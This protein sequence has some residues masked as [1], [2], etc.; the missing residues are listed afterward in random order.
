MGRNN[1]RPRWQPRLPHVGAAAAC[2]A[3]AN[4]KPLDRV[5]PALQLHLAPVFASSFARGASVKSMAAFGKRGRGPLSFSVFRD[6]DDER[7]DGRE[8]PQSRPRQHLTTYFG[9]TDRLALT[10][11][12][13]PCSASRH[14]RC[15]SLNTDDLV[16]RRLSQ[17]LEPVDAPLSQRASATL[18][19]LLSAPASP[20]LSQVTCDSAH[21]NSSGFAQLSPGHQ[22]GS[23][24]LASNSSSNPFTEQ[25]SLSD[26]S[27][28][29]TTSNS[30]LQH[31]SSDLTDTTVTDAPSITPDYTFN[32]RKRKTLRD[33]AKMS[34]ERKPKEQ[35]TPESGTPTQMTSR[36]ASSASLL[37][38]VSGVLAEKSANLKRSL[39]FLPTAAEPPKP[40]STLSIG[41][42]YDVRQGAGAMSNPPRPPKPGEDHRE[43]GAPD[44]VER[45]PII[46]EVGKIAEDQM[47]DKRQASNANGSEP[48]SRTQQRGS[49]DITVA[50]REESQPSSH[51]GVSMGS[52]SMECSAGGAQKG[53]IYSEESPSM[54]AL[55]T[56]PPT[57]MGLRQLVSSANRMSRLG[58]NEQ[59]SAQSIDKDDGVSIS[60]TAA[61]LSA[62]KQPVK[63]S[64]FQKMK[65]TF[66]LSRRHKRRNTTFH[67]A[68]E[69]STPI[70]DNDHQPAALQGNLRASQSAAMLTS[71]S[72]VHIGRQKSPS[73]IEDVDLVKDTPPMRRHH[74]AE[75]PPIKSG[76]EFTFSH[77]SLLGNAGKAP[78][79]RDESRPSSESQ[80]NIPSAATP[81]EITSRA[82]SANSA[83]SHG[84]GS[85]DGRPPFTK[86]QHIP[87][88]LSIAGH[89]G[90]HCMD[91]LRSHGNILEFAEYPTVADITRPSATAQPVPAQVLPAQAAPGQTANAQIAAA[92]APTHDTGSPAGSLHQNATLEDVAN[93]SEFTTIVS[94]NLA[95]T[96]LTS[97]SDRAS[98]MSI[99]GVSPRRARAGTADSILAGRR[100]RNRRSKCWNNQ[101]LSP[102]EMMILRPSYDF[103]WPMGESNNCDHD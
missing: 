91:P 33:L 10:P 34:R 24:P 49:M 47:R 25:Q 92:M 98:H 20:A 100:L 19:E 53:I 84:S 18:S 8:D 60:N 13:S 38:K 103:N 78:I 54:T 28:T 51:N 89:N 88:G 21:F 40:I 50:P 57:V 36:N 17:A 74:F 15:T 32:L 94:P 69:I 82:G 45:K 26:R 68:M 75:L 55:P 16:I 97:T 4:V 67:S 37:S 66:N 27:D 12:V 81:D 77:M 2:D 29:V 3:N 31:Q 79:S 85:E 23:D 30:S 41:A 58:L 71:A 63:E 14:V 11:T 65:N 9:S 90:L 64:I 35:R 99:S 1:S 52:S 48:R 59:V 101:L 39:P 102:D 61:Q 76:P 70:K 6:D 73:P 93:P 46:P 83:K 5:L 22:T 43:W 7:R 86:D 56:R 87:A 96:D 72:I 44:L 95:K 80:V 62:D 42:P